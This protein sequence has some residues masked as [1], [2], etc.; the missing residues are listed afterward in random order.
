MICITGLEKNLSDLL[1]RL[2]RCREYPLQEV[3][4]DVL[5]DPV[6]PAE[7]LPVP[8]DQILITCRK[9]AD[10]GFFKGSEE[11]RAL[12][13][14]SALAWKPGWIDLEADISEP[15]ESY[16][17]EKARIAGVKALRSLHLTE[18]CQPGDIVKSLA[19]LS[20]IYGE[21]I[22]LAALVD[23]LIRLEE[24]FTAPKTRTSVLIG[25]G[26]AGLI[27]R[28]LSRRFN[29]KWSYVSETPWPDPDA[30]IPDLSD[31]MRFGMP[32]TEEASLYVL[33]GG[34]SITRS[35]GPW[36]YNHLF[37]ARNFHG[38]YLPAITENLDHAFSLLCRL[39]I[40]GASITIPHKLAAAELATELS[41]SARLTGSVNTLIA[42]P[43]GNW[44]GENTDIPAVQALV[45]RLASGSLKKAAVLGTGGLARACAFALA[46][47]S[48]QV[49]LLGRRKTVEEDPWFRARHLK[50]IYD[51]P[52]DVLVNATPLGSNP[53]DRCPI[54]DDLPLEGKIVLDAVLS[55]GP[56]PLLTQA[57][58]AGARLAG[59]LEFWTEQGTRQM[60]LL[61]GPKATPA[62][63][64]AIAAEYLNKWGRQ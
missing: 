3:R 15:M 28:V 53:D 25:M 39:G 49:T 32:V 61:G 23:E 31:A 43:E 40:R 42:G 12:R 20:R 4:L 8:P 7:T 44:R 16:L 11:D 22:K 34:S 54:P 30:G 2:T 35:P 52:F 29:S 41:K 6:P 27:S 37:K 33:L 60:E 18:T 24:L 21:G 1:K 59:G 13:L 50:E 9:A 62:E 55:P 36:V 45:D 57:S 58:S 46:E 63:L 47:K 19:I 10:G 17:L 14:E 56:T 5:Q 38:V 26:P 51:V 48:M 64:A